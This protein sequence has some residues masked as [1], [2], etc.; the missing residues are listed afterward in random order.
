MRASLWMLLVAA[1]AA[2]VAVVG[3]PVYLIQP[4]AA[5]T[6]GDVEW[7]WALKRLAPWVTGGAFLLIAVLASLLW[8]TPHEAGFGRRSAAG[9]RIRVA[10]RRVAL[11]AAVGVAGGAAWFAQQNHFEWMFRPFPD[12]RFVAA[13]DATD[14]EA[15]EPIIGVTHGDDALAFPIRRIGYHHLVNTTIANVPI[16]ATY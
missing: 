4:F 9:R 5:Q 13:A 3:V 1:L 6:A 16:V 12:P 15:G 2:A 7:S 14:L 11:A 8:R 10:A